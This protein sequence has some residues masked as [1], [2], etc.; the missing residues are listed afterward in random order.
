M[1]RKR[2]RQKGRRPIKLDPRPMQRPCGQPLLIGCRSRAKGRLST[3]C[4]ER[5]KGDETEKK[6][7]RDTKR[8]RQWKRQRREREEC[9]NCHSEI[10]K[11]AVCWTKVR[12]AAYF[13]RL[14]AVD[15]LAKERCVCVCV[16]VSQESLSLKAFLLHTSLSLCSLSF[17]L[18]GAVHLLIRTA[19][20][21]ATA[22]P[23]IALFSRLWRRHSLHG[24]RFLS[25]TVSSLSPFSVHF[26]GL[27]TLHLPRHFSLPL[28]TLTP[29]CT[30]CR[31]P[32]KARR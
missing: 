16:C 18:F 23:P 20:L 10:R 28:I 7:R 19:S 24:E 26:F 3:L 9:G 4:G 31:P 13:I 12:A 6:R 2:R 29:T 27:L 15:L 25:F 32:R 22:F 11:G 5:E 21:T 1:K 17:S 30:P 14:F 8:M